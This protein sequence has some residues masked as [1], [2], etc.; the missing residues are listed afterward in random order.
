MVTV[1]FQALPHTRRYWLDGID[2]LAVEFS[3]P[4]HL[5]VRG[6]AWCADHSTQW[7]VPCEL[8][9][10]FASETP[11][12]CV[13]RLGDASFATLDEHR[14]RGAT[15]TQ[16]GWLHIF[17]FTPDTPDPGLLERSLARLHAWLSAHPDN[18]GLVAHDWSYLSPSEAE[19]LIRARVAEG[20][21]LEFQETWLEGRKTLRL[22]HGG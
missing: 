5:L 7:L 13:A 19:A 14:T 1:A 9:V 21:H 16:T 11:V 12:R 10:I 15:H 17:R 3:S 20:Q 18:P 8:E 2:P 4:G 22:H 6:K